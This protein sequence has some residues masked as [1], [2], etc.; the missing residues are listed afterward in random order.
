MAI[1]LYSF[2][3]HYSILTVLRQV[4]SL[5][6]TNYLLIA[7]TLFL[8][9]YIFDTQY[10]LSTPCF[11]I[12]LFNISYFIYNSSV[13][14]L[15]SCPYSLYI[16]LAFLFLIHF[17][18]PLYQIFYSNRPYCI[19]HCAA[20]RWQVEKYNEHEYITNMSKLSNGHLAV[21]LKHI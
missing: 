11:Q 17:W 10:S 4:L 15:F 20:M 7:S 5:S 18:T 21:L 8:N 2:F 6:W 9:K 19:M 3:F 12:I 14:P 16:H 1:F 13:F